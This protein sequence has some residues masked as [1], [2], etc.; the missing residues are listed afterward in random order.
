MSMRFAGRLSRTAFAELVDKR[1]DEIRAAT[2]L[3]ALY[4]L[5]GWSGPARIGSWGWEN[6]V[7]STAGLAFGVPAG[8]GP[9]AE[10]VTTAGPAEEWVYDQRLAA[11][12][13][14]QPPQDD[15]TFQRV[16]D[17]VEAVRPAELA[18]DVDGV[19]RTFRHWPA[20]DGHPGWYAALA[21]APG[22]AVAARGL[23]PREV[24]LV[25]VA[26]VEP[27]LAAA[28]VDVL[29]TY[30]AAQPPPDRP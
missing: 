7:L 19:V 24:R 11:A 26:D 10:V 8:P 15:E 20:R 16:V 23:E 21:G 28:R 5:A 27:Y 1:H 29:T 6:G 13:A 14:A 18:L 12:L 2:G 3:L 22:L 9:W 25:P 4:G 17:A 30:D